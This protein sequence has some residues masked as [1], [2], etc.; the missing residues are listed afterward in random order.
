MHACIFSAQVESPYSTSPALD[1]AHQGKTIPRGVPTA[2]KAPPA[3]KVQAVARP[4]NAPIVVPK[5]NGDQVPALPSPR[6]LPAKRPQQEEGTGVKMAR[7]LGNVPSCKAALPK[8]APPK[9]V[10]C[11]D[12]AP[13]MDAVSDSKG[14]PEQESSLVFAANAPKPSSERLFQPTPVPAPS[15]APSVTPTVLE[16]AAPTAGAD[17]GKT[18][19]SKHIICSKN[20]TT[21]LV[22]RHVDNNWGPNLCLRI[23]F[24]TV[25]FYTSCICLF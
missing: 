3:T 23:R 5:V 12:L 13:E 20:E 11:R 18:E 17:A 25:T 8:P 7:L 4:T 15:T 16:S 9:P 6:G 19:S 22:Y 14:S 2:T 21:M 24:T 1:Y 10:H